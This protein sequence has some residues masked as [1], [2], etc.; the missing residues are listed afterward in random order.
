M[1]AARAAAFF[2]IARGEA[3]PE[4]KLL[5][6][7]LAEGYERQAKECSTAPA[8]SGVRYPTLPGGQAAAQIVD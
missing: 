5:F 4:L 6:Q 2:A 7:E 3:H 8:A 1:L